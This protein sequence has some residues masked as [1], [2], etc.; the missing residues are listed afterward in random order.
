MSWQMMNDEW[1]SFDASFKRLSWWIMISSFFKAQRELERK[2]DKCWQ[3][4]ETNRCSP[5]KQARSY[6]PTLGGAIFD[7]HENVYHLKK[8][9]RY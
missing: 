6:V 1:I 3:P 8:T 4:L 2:T 9:C 5:P 7:P